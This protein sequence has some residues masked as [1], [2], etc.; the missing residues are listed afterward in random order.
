M[1]QCRIGSSRAGVAAARVRHRPR[2]SSAM[3]AETP[4]LGEF[5]LIQRFFTRR[6]APR[7][8][9]SGVIL[10]IGDD[11]AVL[12]L[13]PETDLVAAVDT[14]LPA[15]PFPVCTAPPSPIPHAPPL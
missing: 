10:G 3:S 6:H 11:A 9:Q 15:P 2:L 1:R 4:H 13:P 14:T 5:E 12:A 7:A 8:A